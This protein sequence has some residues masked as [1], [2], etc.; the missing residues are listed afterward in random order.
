MSIPV[1]TVFP[2]QG[3]DQPLLLRG[4]VADA[5]EAIVYETDDKAIL[6]KIYHQPTKEQAEKIRAMVAAPPADPS[7]RPGHRSFT[8]PLDSVLDPHG[9]FAGF[10]MPAVP[11]PH[12]ATAWASPKLRR[13]AG[14]N[15]SWSSLHAV[16]ANLAFVV[17][18]LNTAGIVLGDLKTDNVLVDTHGLVTLIDCD[19]FQVPCKDGD[20]LLCRVTTEDFCA[21]ELFG[22][23]LAEELREE[24]A[25]R[26][27]LA[28]AIFKLLF[29]ASPFSGDWRGG[30]EPATPA[31]NASAGRWIWGGD[32][33]LAPPEALPDVE[34]I[35][36]NLIRFFDRAFR[37]GASE[38][39]NRPT[40]TE[41]H[42]TLC[43]VMSE[44]GT[45]STDPVHYH[46][47]GS[48]CPWCRQ[49]LAIGGS[50][51]DAQDDTITADPLN[52]LVQTFERALAR[53]DTRMAVDLWKEHAFLADRLADCAESIADFQQGLAAF[54][55]W[56]N[57]VEGAKYPDGPTATA[58]L[59]EWQHLEPTVAPWL[60]WEDINGDDVQAVVATLRQA[61]LVKTQKA[62]PTVKSNA[63]RRRPVGP[64]LAGPPTI[65]I[66][67]P[68][69]PEKTTSDK[70]KPVITYRITTGW[71]DLKPAQLTIETTGPA[72]L[73]ELELIDRLTGQ[74][75]VS[76]PAGRIIDRLVVPFSQ[77]ITPTVVILA[78]AAGGLD[79]VEIISP[80]VRN[81]TI[82]APA[83]PP[84]PP[85]HVRKV[86]VN[87]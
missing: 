39:G 72:V 27:S 25:D 5:G 82:G 70:K 36:P 8:W 11:A 60:A 12:S 41:W 58:L 9:A 48:P 68:I 15:V 67:E 21:P 69:I 78:V 7:V 51:F 57:K 37:A 75:L 20:P 63:A 56:R 79:T 77:P 10:L 4:I 52:P 23:D 55:V 3:G 81:R 86:F 49:R 33:F 19:S 17:G 45:C 14:L 38:P 74:A 61:A 40:G 65:M 47:D 85:P 24:T 83:G 32:A 31:A 22:K 66:K 54:D 1:R 64:L 44:I 18:Q 30:G 35:H 26:F 71:V 87:A 29:G 43:L 28:V 59:D 84:A 76:C 53:G 34:T 6:A 16:A 2:S 42:E 46:Y 62:K 50:T 73:P 13:R 80:P